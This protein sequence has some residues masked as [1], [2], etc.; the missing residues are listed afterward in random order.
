M[1]RYEGCNIYALQLL[2]S[3]AVGLSPAPS[4]GGFGPS[5]ETIYSRCKG[6]P[7][8]IVQLPVRDKISTCYWCVDMD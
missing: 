5:K 7:N 3:G 8:L 2:I 4:G 1:C 6:A